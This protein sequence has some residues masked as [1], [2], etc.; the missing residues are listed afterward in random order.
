MLEAVVQLIL[1]LEI[2]EVSSKIIFFLLCIP[3]MVGVPC[4]GC[5]SMLKESGQI[6]FKSLEPT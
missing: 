2:Y 6:H 5:G 4:S 1:L 3:S